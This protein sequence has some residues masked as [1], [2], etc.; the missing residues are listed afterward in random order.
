MVKVS[1]PKDSCCFASFDPKTQALTVFVINKNTADSEVRIEVGANSRFRTAE[2]YN[3]AGT[4]EADMKPT[5]SRVG[6]MDVSANILKGVVL[7]GTSIT[8][9][10]MKTGD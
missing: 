6:T 1:G 3:F 5:W 7:P 9:L 4:G 10:D 8:V 2:V